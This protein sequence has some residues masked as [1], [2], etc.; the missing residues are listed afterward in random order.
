M[1]TAT[2]DVQEIVNDLIEICRDGKQGFETAANAVNDGL[3][4]KEFLHHARERATFVNVLSTALIELGY[5]PVTHGTAAGALHRGWIHMTNLKPGDN[6]H[7]VLAACERGED[8]ALRAYTEAM[9]AMIPG[10]LGELIA[11]QYLVVKSAHDRIRQMR[12][13]AKA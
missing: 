3:L 10:R 13:A 7:A 9:E 11:A 8:S 2:K 5:E 1:A 4:K 6:E 12:D